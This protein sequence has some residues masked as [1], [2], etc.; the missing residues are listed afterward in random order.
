VCRRRRDRDQDQGS[1]TGGRRA[2]KDDVVI[3][4]RGS[5]VEEPVV[6]V[7]VEIEIQGGVG[8]RALTA[9]QPF[10]YSGLHLL[11]VFPSLS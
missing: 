5:N 9:T 7:G 3:P 11:P 6:R 1:G 2:Q 10:D 4:H 8:G